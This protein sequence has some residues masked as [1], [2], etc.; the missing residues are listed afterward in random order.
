MIYIVYKITNT[1]NNKIYV[2]KHQTEDIRDDYLGSGKILK[3][4][5]DKYGVEFFKKEI[6]YVFDEKE[7]MD[8]MEKEIVNEEFVRRSD[9]PII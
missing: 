2:G 9:I 1:V 4:A 6:L 7:D 8:Y 5:I 3:K